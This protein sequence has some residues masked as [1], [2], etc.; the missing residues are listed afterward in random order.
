MFS[1]VSEKYAYVAGVDTHAQKHVATVI[2]HTGAIRASREIRVTARQLSGFID[3]LVKLAGGTDKLLLAVEGTSSYGETLTNFA[4]AR[5]LRVTEVRPPRLKSRG[6]A[7]KSDPIDAELAALSVLRLPVRK[8]ITPRYGEQR[9]VLRI[10]LG[11]RRNMVVK[12]TMDKNALMALLRGIELGIDARRPLKLS[13]YQTISRWCS[14]AGDR[15]DQ[16]IAR[17]EAIRLAGSIIQTAGNLKQNKLAL[18]EAV[19]ALTPDLLNEPGCGP[20]SLAQ[21]ICAYS[22][23]GRVHSG[24]AFAA[25]AGTTP[26]PA[27]SGN[28]TRH[29]L[30][31]YGD[32]RLNHAIDTIAMARMRTDETTQQ[33]VAKRTA[34]GLSKR[35]VKRTLKRYIARSL[36]KKLEACDIKL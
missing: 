34:E 7:G 18:H 14:Q 26:L 1:I 30:N 23:K 11:A 13:N 24:S 10:L 16:A 9:K 25:L 2:D 15:P 31:P 27:S 19:T 33:Y 36:Y 5:G 3:W 20:V 4:L 29:R 22:H 21:A 17:S 32:R 35:E 6:G 8:L 12:Q 28:V